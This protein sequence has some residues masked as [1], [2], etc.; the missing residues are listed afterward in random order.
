VIA[1]LQLT[2]VLVDDSV[3]YEYLYWPN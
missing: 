3:Q 1:L 2:P